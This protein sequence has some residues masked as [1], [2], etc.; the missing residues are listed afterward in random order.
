LGE[1]IESSM[2]FNKYGEIVE[3]ELFI[4]S[5]KRPH[6]QLDEYIIMPNHIH[7]IIF[8]I[9]D[10]G[11]MRCIAR[12]RLDKN[13]GQSTGWP[14]HSKRGSLPK[15]LNEFVGNFKSFATKRINKINNSQGSPLWQRNYF[16][17]I[18]KNP[19]ELNK[20]REYIIN[21]TKNWSIDKDNPNKLG[22]ITS[23]GVM[24][25]ITRNKY[26][27]KKRAIHRIAPTFIL[28]I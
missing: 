3:E 8:I 14:L 9:S 19:A 6:I 20:T 23:V 11:A 27:N 26:Y 25:C 1:V 10:V 5:E 2:S 24:R 18:I 17:H 12:N 13:S 7:A 22:Q 16:E 4:A 15:S 28:R 21:N